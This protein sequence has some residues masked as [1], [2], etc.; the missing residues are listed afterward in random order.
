MFAAVLKESGHKYLSRSYGNRKVWIVYQGSCYKIPEN[1]WY[2]AN[3]NS[4]T[5]NQSENKL[6]FKMT[7]ATIEILKRELP[8]LKEGVFLKDYTTFKIGGPAELFLIAENEATLIKAIKIAKEHDI[9][10]FPFG[11][12]SNLL[13]SD[14]G[15]KGL[16]IKQHNQQF[17]LDGNVITAGGGIDMKEMVDFSIEHSLKGLE[18]AGGLPGT[19]GG[20]VRGNAGAFGGE[21][22][23]TILEVT[24]LD[25]N[26]ELRTFSK[27]E[28]DF[29]YRSST[30]KKNNWV[31]VTVKLQLETGDQKALRE[32]ADSRIAYRKERHPL[33]FPNSG[34][35]FKNVAYE[36]FNEEFKEV[37]VNSI[38][39]D[40][41]P[42]IPTAILISEADLKGTTIGK[43]QVSE[44]HP[45]FIINLG[46][47]TAEDVASLISLVKEK[48][49]DKY[50]I[51]LE[52]EVQ[53]VGF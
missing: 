33:D 5:V 39:K 6:T 26:L 28:C 52:P 46:G 14:D 22:K 43:A 48:I 44:K 4:G 9:P 11:G 2:H 45:N 50:D 41:F 15:I 21:I 13:V 51:E 7:T 20:A 47:A 3:G 30:F 38:K 18:W 29:A 35:I 12:G 1:A 53:F 32:I 24:A 27:E 42:V 19:L 17:S 8:E 31:V 34:S 25:N 37:F 10:V 23:D 36:K 49:K 16:V 40:P